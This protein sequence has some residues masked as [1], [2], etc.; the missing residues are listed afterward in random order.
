[1]YDRSESRALGKRYLPKTNVLT[2][3]QRVVNA[4]SAPAP[5]R[6]GPLIHL[7]LSGHTHVGY[8]VHGKLPPEVPR[9]NKGKLH[10]YQLQLV[11][12]A[13]LSPPH[14]DL[15]AGGRTI[16]GAFQAQIVR[17]YTKGVPG[18]LTIQRSVLLKRPGQSSYDIPEHRGRE[19]E[20]L[21]FDY[22]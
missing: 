4:L 16:G 13:L 19:Y 21:V 8:P 17:F 1:P 15:A 11:N 9:H 7:I 20:E 14:V 3:V 10:P 5:D 6:K 12:G 18:R 2:D 22:G